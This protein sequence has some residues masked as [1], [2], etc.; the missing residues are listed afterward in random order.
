MLRALD[1]TNE[2]NSR[3][4]TMK[5]GTILLSALVSIG[6]VSAR[7]ADTYKVDPV[8]SYVGFSIS[9]MVI[10]NVKGKFKDFSGSLVVDGSALKE[11]NGSV[12]T[13]SVDTSNQGR[14][15]HLSSSDFF[16]AEKFPEMTFKSK[17][18]ETSGGKSTLVGDFTMHGVT[19]EVSLA[20]KLSGPIKDPQGKMRVGL[21][22]TGE[23][24]RKDFGMTFNKTMDNG[25]LLVGDSVEIEI[26]AE[27]VQAAAQ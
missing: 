6:L 9:H 16:D 19:K 3:Y 4:K 11:A 12:Q 10:N 14:D 13:K 8:H 23:L 24:S 18:V 5:T 26:N 1:L 27:A 2:H 22:A 21:K 25:G 7:A 20:A 17:R 15:R